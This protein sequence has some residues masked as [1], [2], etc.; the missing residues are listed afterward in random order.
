MLPAVKQVLQG[1]LFD[2]NAQRVLA[3]APRYTPT[4]PS[5]I[6]LKTWFPSLVLV[7]VCLYF[8]LKRSD[9]IF[10]DPLNMLIHEAGHLCFFFLGDGL[11]AAGGTLMQILLPATLACHFWQYHSRLGMQVSLLWLGQN[12]LNISVYAAD[13]R[14]Q[15]LDLLGGRT[16]DWSYL[17]DRFGLLE[18]DLVFAFFFCFLALMTFMALLALPF[19]LEVDR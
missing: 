7:P 3:L 6:R 5:W 14:V 2:A 11:H 18:Y 12:F 16:H 8:V 4:V 17:L 9:G 13:A 10:L 19:Y 1:K 15:G